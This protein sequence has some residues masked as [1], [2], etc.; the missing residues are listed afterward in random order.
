MAYTYSSDRLHAEHEGVLGEVARV[1]QRIL[2]PQLAEQIVEATHVPEVVGKV[3]LKERVD[4]AA[5]HKPH[6]CGQVAGAGIG[7]Q[8][9]D[10]DIRDAKDGDAARSEYEQEIQGA[11]FVSQVAHNLPLNG[12]V[13]VLARDKRDVCGSHGEQRRYSIGYEYDER[14]QMQMQKNK[15]EEEDESGRDASG[16]RASNG[17]TACFVVPEAGLRAQNYSGAGGEP[18]LAAANQM[19]GGGRGKSVRDRDSHAFVLCQRAVTCFAA[20]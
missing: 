3:A 17:G 2:L 18:P 16:Q 14:M 13:R 1:A 6:Y 5:Q 10:H 9:L 12:V 20:V 19:G 4:A 11:P 15:G 8:T 7:S